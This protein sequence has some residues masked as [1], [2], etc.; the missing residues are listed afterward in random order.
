MDIRK[1][2]GKLCPSWAILLLFLWFLTG[3]H[4]GEI[5]SHRLDVL[6][7]FTS[8]G[9]L[10]ESSTASSLHQHSSTST[11]AHPGESLNL[12]HI[13]HMDSGLVINPWPLSQPCYCISYP[14]LLLPLS[15]LTGCQ[16]SLTISTESKREFLYLLVKHSGGTPSSLCIRFAVA[17]AITMRLSVRW[18]PQSLE[19]EIGHDYPMFC[20]FFSTWEVRIHQKDILPPFCLN[21]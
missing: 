10:L 16:F 1:Y 12:I 19:K 15:K 21:H 13:L 9:H 8:Q 5:F 11:L 6:L 20:T 2:N 7:G 18:S 4:G 14:L 17:A 3:T